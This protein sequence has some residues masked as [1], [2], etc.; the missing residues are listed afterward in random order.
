MKKNLYIL[1]AALVLTSPSITRANAEFPASTQAQQ[2]TTRQIKG[3]IVDAKGEP[4]IGATITIEQNKAATS[5]VSGYYS[6]EAPEGEVS[7]SIR[8][9]TYVSQVVKVSPQ[10]S[11]VNITMQED[12][13]QLDNVVVVGYG[14]MKK[15][16][17]TSSIV[18]VKAKDIT[19]ISTGNA[20]NA[21]QG[22]VAGVQI[23]EGGGP[24][25]Q[26][27]VII[28]GFTSV[29][30]G[31]DPLYVIDGI[32]MGTNMNSI[33]PNEIEKIE[34][35]KDASAAAI[36]GSQ[37][38]NGVI[39]VTTKKGVIGKAV[40]N[41]DVSTG[42]HFMQQPYSMANAEQ[43]AALM[44]TATDNAGLPREFD[45][46]DNYIGKTTDWWGAGIKKLSQTSSVSLNVQGGSQKHT[47]ALN[48][49]YY[50]DDSFYEKGGWKKFTARLTNDYTISEI[51][52]AGV[53]L[54]PRWESW[55]SP[56]NWADF[57][58][59]DP[60]TPIYKAPEDLTG[61]ENEYS[62]F[63]RSPSYVWNP[64]ASVK[65][66]NNSNE[67]YALVSNTYVQ[68][69]PLKGLIIRSQI[70]A[71][72]DSRISST[73]SPDFV[74]DA[75]HEYQN[76]NKV[77]RNTNLYFNWSW[78]NTITY[79][80]ELG[81]HNLTA[82]VGNTMDQWNGTSLWG[83]KFA[84]PNNSDPLQELDAATKDPDAGGSRNTSSLLSYFGRVSYNFDSKYYLTTTARWDGSS[85][86]LADNKWAF[87]PSVSAA[88]RVTN[89]DFMSGTSGWLNELKL[90]A[91]WGRVGNQNLPSG[92]YES[93]VGKGYYTI[94]DMIANTTYPTAMSNKAVKWETVEDINV[95]IDFSMLNS[96]LSGS[97]EY[98]T[99]NTYD[100]LFLK[101]YPSYSGYPDDAKIWSNVGSMNVKG[102]EFAINH[103]NTLGDF[104]YGVNLT[105]TTFDVKMTSLANPKEPLYGESNRTR[106][107]EGS[108]PGYY[109]GYVADGIFQNRWELN[110]HTSQNG[111]ILQPNAVAGDIRFLD[112][113]GDGVLNA[114]DRTKIGS[115][116]ADFTA[117]L[118]IDMSYKR[119]D[120][121][122]NF[123][124]SVGND[125]VNQLKNN[126][127]NAID[128]TNKLAN[129]GQTAWNGEGSS[130]DIPRLSRVDLNENY[131]KFS[132]FY[133]EDGSFLKLKNV[134]LG[135]T[136]LNNKGGFRKLR[137]YVAAQNLFT[138]TKYKGIDPEIGGGV[139]EFGFGEWNYPTMPTF[140]TGI[141]IS[142]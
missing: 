114:E 99:K 2:N 88:W 18:G 110:S 103:N 123:Y 113:N 107:D 129:L 105:F 6:I 13:F 102:F 22:K 40:F 55:G 142:F 42:V 108:V 60:I 61:D 59:I 63:A 52:T 139:L 53:T 97:V 24:G 1:M 62:I 75:A 138:I 26:P 122:L 117:G 126:L 111:N 93:K 19:A 73:F 66:F 71:D 48:L 35:L 16:D 37:A 12:V 5:D 131:S 94:G 8:C 137:L 51:F 15:S 128:K 82:M 38:S 49:S 68:A 115:P 44:N 10:Q 46:P 77:E 133:I 124:A 69:K 31:T 32:P 11:E 127:H 92:V 125:A 65:R 96:K 70:G 34:V 101:S 84:V 90:R 86:F 120:L 58:R 95:G 29:N 64:V 104:S 4:V 17:L 45:N 28:R 56:S 98:Y 121:L 43:Y 7:L 130:N 39:L 83:A 23:I 116:W 72:V 9:L 30:L 89:E 47:Y 33:N 85:K 57:V 135:Y 76:L 78:Q 118:N 112:I 134:Q 14:S 141:N 136:F 79:M 25:A 80:P 41:V 27:K 74:I 21:L 36:Y 81:K 54:N 109:Y 140:I 50:T 3:Q 67:S 106:T 20:M 132:S 91:G 100:M 119:F 87:F